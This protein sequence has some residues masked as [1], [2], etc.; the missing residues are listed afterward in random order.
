MIFPLRQGTL[1]TLP[2]DLNMLEYLGS[3]G[4]AYAIS[5]DWIR[6]C[7]ESDRV[8]PLGDFLVR[9]G[10]ATERG[11][12]TE[13]RSSQL[14]NRHQEGIQA[15]MDTQGRGTI[16]SGAEHR[17]ELAYGLQHHVPDG[18]REQSQRHQERV[19]TRTD[20]QERGLVSSG[21][22]NRVHSDSRL[23]H[24]RPDIQRGHVRRDLGP[25]GEDDSEDDSGIP[26]QAARRTIRNTTALGLH[27]M[28]HATSTSTS[29]S[30]ST[31]APHSHSLQARPFPLPMPRSPFGWSNRA[32][33]RAAASGKSPTRLDDSD[34]DIPLRLQST[35][36]VRAP[37]PVTT[38]PN[39]PT[40]VK[41]SLDAIQ[42]LDPA[43]HARDD[44]DGDEEATPD[45]PVFRLPKKRRLTA[46]LACKNTDRETQNEDVSREQSRVG[47]G[48]RFRD[49]GS[50]LPSFKRIPSGSGDAGARGGQRQEV[51]HTFEEVMCARLTF[52]GA[53]GGSRR[54]I[55]R[56]REE[57]YYVR[58]PRC[59]WSLARIS[60][61]RSSLSRRR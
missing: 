4:T 48:E 35:A 29:T 43:K 59:Q 2:K 18:E 13:S 37:G 50:R 45:L 57:A 20:G 36:P 39:M 21:A 41:R 40:P 28:K 53:R 27:G 51:R 17:Q 11:P 60:A 12:T 23:Q 56:P 19:Q 34:V 1:A 26:N 22:E 25:I 32:E 9:E 58:N 8:V 7:D 24:D 5:E 15:S 46:K 10:E 47:Q 54:E 42:G 38:Y 55:P 33:G 14:Q 49:F 52:A 61:R 6:E 31:S 16:S 30:A 3:L 44:D